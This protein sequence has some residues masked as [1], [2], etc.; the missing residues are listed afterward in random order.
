MELMVLIMKELDYK[1]SK[2]Q[3]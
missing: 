1:S 3:L 2:E